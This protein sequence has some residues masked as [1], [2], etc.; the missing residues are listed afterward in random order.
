[1]N[2]FW[3]LVGTSMYWISTVIVNVNMNVW[4]IE[5][6]S[7]RTCLHCASNYQ[8]SHTFNNLLYYICWVSCGCASQ[9]TSYNASHTHFVMAVFD[10]QSL[11]CEFVN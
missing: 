10:G 7:A 2:T 8:G 1:M 3:Q 11:L 6:N 4:M 9:L 5:W